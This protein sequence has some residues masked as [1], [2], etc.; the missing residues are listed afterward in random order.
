MGNN[1]WGTD[2]RFRTCI[3]NRTNKK[4]IEKKNQHYVTELFKIHALSLIKFKIISS[5]SV[6]LRIL[7]YL[8]LLLNKFKAWNFLSTCK[9]NINENHDIY[10]ERPF[11]LQQI[12]MHLWAT[13]LN[14]KTLVHNPANSAIKATL[15]F[16]HSSLVDELYNISQDTTLTKIK[17]LIE[18]KV[19]YFFYF[20]S[21]NII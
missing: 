7:H 17:R 8:W 14:N 5:C 10:S 6:L 18:W 1:I 12:S 16:F 15:N 11:S 19:F 21:K 3:T 20:T 13:Y 4:I 9:I 2:L